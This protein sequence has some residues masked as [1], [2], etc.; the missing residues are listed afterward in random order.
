M[1]WQVET[2]LR[3]MTHND[4]N[5]CNPRTICLRRQPGTMKMTER[6]IRVAP[7]DSTSLSSASSLAIWLW[8]ATYLP[9]SI[10]KCN[11]IIHR[12]IWLGDALSVN[13]WITIGYHLAFLRHLV[14]FILYLTSMNP[15]TLLMH[16]LEEA[17][18]GHLIW[19]DILAYVHLTRNVALVH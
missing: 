15:H 8:I 17:L 13:P 1:S 18:I 9:I 10:Y 6:P 2:S 7:V 12:P 4:C 3:T 14:G 19:L 16:R 11:L 5:D